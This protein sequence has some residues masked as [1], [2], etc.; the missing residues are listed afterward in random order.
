MRYLSARD[1]AD[2]VAPSALVLALEQGL[3][4]FARH[5]L[6]IPAR[7][8]LDFGGNALLTMPAVG[9]TRFGVKVVSVVPA[10]ASR[11]LPVVKGLMMLSDAATGE[12]LAVID[13]S[14]LTAQRTG[15]VTALAIKY[16][17]RPEV[18]RLGIIG[19][20][21]QGTW[22]A[23]FACAVRGIRRLAYFARSDESARRFEAALS[24]AI[25]SVH[26]VRCAD[27][28]DLL[29]QS[30]VVI[31]AT[32]SSEPVLPA[33]QEL[34]ENR[35]FL[36]VGSF[37]PTM[38]ELP[39]EVYQLAGVVVVDSETAATEAGDLVRPLATGALQTEDIIH[40]ASVV[41]GDRPFV[42]DRTTAFKSVGMALYDLYAAQ[43]FFDEARRLGRGTK[44][45]P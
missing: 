45:E 12:P 34:L 38:Q 36:S 8:H 44:L 9:V 20:G 30:E 1:L 19:T 33:R 4:D 29:V 3:R 25:P 39:A 5:R 6:H 16:T 28:C 40:L 2:L 18:E 32:T 26:L 22:Q 21:V 11:G 10:N 37:R 24:G 27:V 7:Q 42:C 43:T 31:A 17:T 35:H 13:A 15:A 23:I 41:T 14:M